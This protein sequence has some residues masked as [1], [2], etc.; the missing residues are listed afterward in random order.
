MLA[1]LAMVGGPAWVR[2]APLSS[3]PWAQGCSPSRPAGGRSW[4]ADAGPSS[5]RTASDV[6]NRIVLRQ[7]AALPCGVQ[8]STLVRFCVCKKDAILEAA[9]DRLARYFGAT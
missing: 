8:S 1:V 9:A 7:P 5:R 4:P 2:D 6:R 3:P